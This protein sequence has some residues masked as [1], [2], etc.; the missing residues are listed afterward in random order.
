MAKKVTLPPAKP[1]IKKVVKR[2]PQAAKDGI[3]KLQA[4]I[5]DKPSVKPVEVENEKPLENDNEVNNVSTEITSNESQSATIENNGG[6]QETQ[7][8]VSIPENESAPS[9]PVET[10]AGN[11]A[12]LSIW[13]DIAK[14][15]QEDAN[16]GTTKTVLSDLDDDND[17]FNSLDNL[18]NQANGNDAADDENTRKQGNLVKAG[19][20]VEIMD[21]VFML[22]CLFIT[23]DFTDDNQKKYTLHKDRKKA[24]QSNLYKLYELSG[25]KPNPKKD[26]WFLILGSYAPLLFIAVLTMIKNFKEKNEA[27]KRQATISKMEIENAQIIENQNAELWQQQQYNKALLEEIEQLKSKKANQFEATTIRPFRDVPSHGKTPAVKKPSGGRGV[28]AGQKR[29][30]Y[31]KKK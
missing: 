9:V 13:D 14:S 17:A 16:I 19:I 22:I 24:I 6:A 10:P 27:K 8:N 25:K 5:A 23:W 11:N 12:P 29:G 20:V 2:N 7:Y 3:K 15:T 18:A 30:S 31:N 4:A 21:V 28:K 26:I 1:T